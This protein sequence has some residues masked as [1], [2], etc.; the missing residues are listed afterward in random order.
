MDKPDTV[1]VV[2]GHR[3]EVK[4]N[5]VDIHVTINGSSLVTGNVALKKVKEIAQLMGA[6]NEISLNYE[7]SIIQ[8]VH[9]ES[10]NGF[11][12]KTCCAAYQVRI[13]C[14]DLELLPAILGV[15]TSHKTATLDFLT[16]R[17]PDDP[18]LRDE[19]LHACLAEAKEKADAI[20]A[21]LGVKLLGVYTLSEK[22]VDSEP[23]EPVRANH[24]APRA[25]VPAGHR[26]R[27]AELGFPLSHSKF[28]EIQL[29]TAFRVSALLPESN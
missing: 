21:C 2:V 9:A 3:E 16:W 10:P 17:Y 18:K 25:A 23:A 20:A 5:Q 1:T 6:L 4:A 13:R 22:W 28:V 12:G 11:L 8:S 7:E 24:P 19:W 14:S 29:E 27:N 15:V 26:G